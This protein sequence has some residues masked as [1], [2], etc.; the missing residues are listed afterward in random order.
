VQAEEE[1]ASSV[2]QAATTQAA[3]YVL[4][5]G[6]AG[7]FSA[8]SAFSMNSSGGTNTVTWL[9]PGLARV[10]FPGLG[11]EVGGNV[12][13][14]A[15]ASFSQRCKVQNWFPSGTTLQVFVRCHSITG[16][17][18]SLPFTASYVRRAGTPG[19]EGGYV[20]ADQPSNPY[21]YTPSLTYQWNSA[22]GNN[23]IQRTGTGSYSINFPNQNFL[24]GTVEVTAYGFGNEY[25]KVQNWFPNGS[26]QQVNVKCFAPNGT[27]ADSL[28]TAKFTRGSLNSTNSFAFAWADQPSSPS[29]TTNSLYQFASVASSCGQLTRGPITITRSSTGRYSVKF[30]GFPTTSSFPSH[31]KVTG[32]GSGADTCK[33]LSWGGN[34]VTT[35]D[36]S[37]FDAAGNAADS[38]FVITLSSTMWVIC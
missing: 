33:V 23:T 26:N 1:S 15:F 32:Y 24:G 16:V 9:E 2:T 4:I 17:P 20:W 29:Y 28:F 10:D 7:S 14:T 22:G 19:T 36:V 38:F 37:C 5:E 21:L 25:C 13:V 34:P 11:N 27:P 6:T 31:V 8:L 18:T 35:A 30:N 12:Q 3:G